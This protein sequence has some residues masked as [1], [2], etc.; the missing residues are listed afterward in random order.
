M[1]KLMYTTIGSLIAMHSAFAIDTNPNGNSA[2]TP[3]TIAVFGDWPYN[4]LL[5]DNAALLI[6]SVNADPAVSLVMHVGDIH[7]GSMPCTSAGILPP[8][9]TAN[10]GWNDKIYFDF[11]QFAK[12]VVYTPG[13]NEWTDCHKAKEKSS[14]APLNELAAV[15]NLFFARPGHTLGLSDKT[16]LSQRNYFDPAYPADASYVENVMW[17]DG[18]VVFVTLNV[19]GSNNDTLPWTGAFANPAAQAQQAAARTS[20]DTRWLQSA[21]ELASDSH[22]R[23]VVI[24]LQA[25][26]WDSAA[27][28]AGGDGLNQ[29]TPFVQALADS[30]TSFA[31]P[32]LLLNGDS[33]VYGADRPLADPSSPTG[34]IHHTQAVPNLTRVTVQGSTNAPAEW[35]R[36]TVDTRQSQ[37]FS[38]GNVPYCTNPLTSCQ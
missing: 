33:H 6:N 4:Q 23:A 36:L 11:Q 17:M 37:P 2:A 32:V 20:A 14:G 30:A 38:W 31:G 24:G 35:L 8:I 22:A 26:M 18:K 16:V 9:A 29:Y 10:P 5:L 1:N 12:P 28:A 21:F 34:M 7:S 15:R 25:D 19:P 3:I 13:D 27:L